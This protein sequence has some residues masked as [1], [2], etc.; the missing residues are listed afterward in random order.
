MPWE[1][2]SDREEI[3]IVFRPYNSLVFAFSLNCC[4][5]FLDSAIPEFKYPSSFGMLTYDLN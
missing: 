4:D 1:V 5:I 3:P 2:A